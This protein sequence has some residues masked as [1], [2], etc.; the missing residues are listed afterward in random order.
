M[1][2]KLPKCRSECADSNSK[3]NFAK[4]VQ[5]AVISEPIHF[6][7][8]MSNTR[9]S[10]RNAKTQGNSKSFGEGS[11]KAIMSEGENNESLEMMAFIMAL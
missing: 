5:L 10:Q 2:T 9:S 6:Q 1:V 8:I 3:C 4:L 11:K 7:R